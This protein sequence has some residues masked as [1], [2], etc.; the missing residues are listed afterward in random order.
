MIFIILI[1]NEIGRR[2]IFWQLQLQRGL[3]YAGN[4]GGSDFTGADASLKR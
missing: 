1:S 4:D 3:R 2:G